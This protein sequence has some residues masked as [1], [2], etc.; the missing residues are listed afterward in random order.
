M[1]KHP[2]WGCYCN[3]IGSFSYNDW[4]TCQNSNSN[5]APPS[6]YCGDRI[7][8]SGES[9]SSCSSD[10]GNCSS[11]SNS[12]NSGSSSTS[13]Q[14]SSSNSSSSYCSVPDGSSFEN[15][16]DCDEDSDC[17]SNYYCEQSS[18][19]DACVR[20]NS[21][22]GSGSPS[23]FGVVYV[24]GNSQEGEFQCG[25]K[26]N[27]ACY[28]SKNKLGPQM[29]AQ[30]CA[31]PPATAVCGSMA[32]YAVAGAAFVV[33]ST[34]VYATDAF[35]YIFE[36]INYTPFKD[37]WYDSTKLKNK[38]NQHVDDFINVGLL[39]NGA[40]EG[41]FDKLCRDSFKSGKKYFDKDVGRVSGFKEMGAYGVYTVLEMGK[42]WNCFPKKVQNF[43]KEISK[44]RY[45][46]LKY[47]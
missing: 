27:N 25:Y 35:D 30:V 14:P 26:S 22:S 37:R 42:M 45:K 36:Y 7:C 47:V 1:T 19:A 43:L 16:C 8:N 21:G 17:P 5:S 9:C 38:Y 33:A 18:G 11:S 13:N 32:T 3:S 31:L 2:E 15:N 24:S 6:N 20:T 39:P 28:S 40:S 4:T 23:S 29:Q 10:C 34:V 12:G 46:G 41:D 44:G